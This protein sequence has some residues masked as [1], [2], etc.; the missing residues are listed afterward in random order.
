MKM[1]SASSL[2]RWVRFRI[3][4]PPFARLLATCHLR[5][6]GSGL[7]WYAPRRGEMTVTRFHI[8]ACAATGLSAAASAQNAPKPVA[9][10]D[11]IKVVD[12][13]FNGADT[14][15][16]GFIS[17]AE[18]V[19]QQQ[20]DLDAAKGRINQQLQTKFNQLDTNHDG[21]LSIQEFMGIAPPLKVRSEERRVGKEG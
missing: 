3:I 14:N 7:G 17:R 2:S 13:H 12:G 10:A 18:L 6:G 9:R 11:Y 15:H 8:L 20:R 19:A 1:L 16:D 21:K 5:R 4:R